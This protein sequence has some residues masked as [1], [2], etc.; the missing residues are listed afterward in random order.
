[1]QALLKVCHIDRAEQV[2]PDEVRIILRLI[3]DVLERFERRLAAASPDG[4]SII[5]E[6]V[7]AL[8]DRAPLCLKKITRKIPERIPRKALQ[9]G[10][11][12]VDV[13][14]VPPV[15]HLLCEDRFMRS[16]RL[17]IAVDRRH[18][19]PPF[20]KVRSLHEILSE[21]LEKGLDVLRKVSVL[22]GPERVEGDFVESRDAPEIKVPSGHRIEHFGERMDRAEERIIADKSLVIFEKLFIAVAKEPFLIG[23]NI[24]ALVRPDHDVIRVRTKPGPALLV[25]LP[26]H[27][28]KKVI[29]DLTEPLQ[30]FN[31]ISVRMP[32]FIIKR[33]HA[34]ALCMFSFQNQIICSYTLCVPDFSIDHGRGIHIV[35][36]DRVLIRD[37][38]DITDVIQSVVD[39]EPVVREADAAQ[40]EQIAPSLQIHLLLKFHHSHVSGLKGPRIN[41]LEHRIGP[42][43]LRPLRIL[44]SEAEKRVD[45]LPVEFD[46]HFDREFA[47]LDDAGINFPLVIDNGEI[48]DLRLFLTVV[49]ELGIH[50]QLPVPLSLR[51]LL[52]EVAGDVLLDRGTVVG[53]RV[54][55][56]DLLVDID[57]PLGI[58][59]CL[60]MSLVEK[61]DTVTVLGYRAEVMAD[62]EDRLPG[63]LELLELVVALGL[64]EDVTD[65][66]S[67][68]DDE[69]LRVDIDRDGK[70]EAD[71]HTGG[72][73]LHGLIDE[74][75]DVRERDDVV[76]PRIHLLA[77]E[78]H[79]RPVHIDVLEPCIFLI[80]TSAQ[81]EQGRNS[82]A[83]S[84]T[85]FGRVQNA[86]YDLKDR[87][88]SGT[89]GPD[90]AHA[91]PSSHIEADVLQR[92]DFLIALLSAESERFLQAV[93][94]LVVELILF[95]Y[96]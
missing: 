50:F 56:K 84:H 26:V 7:P 73:G 92:I 70:G 6:E 40:G 91:L 48:N 66:E 27:D 51:I 93:H 12:A 80:E 86:G 78:S 62:E 79:D 39:R 76:E 34:A 18:F 16:D 44:D 42:G 1:M 77:G 71:E 74:I 21:D 82:S 54:V 88:L 37:D 25:D 96:M 94:R 20:P 33:I 23:G 83:D 57:H 28:D 13:P 43:D 19:L 29:R 67:F 49:E 45:Q 8:D 35:E 31:D 69:D 52:V 64:E 89:V 46:L 65:G 32:V 41:A 14:L 95:C 15:L 17:Q 58:A 9:R 87:G 81:L 24:I 59:F 30:K 4:F 47:S 55:D 68:I 22:N 75:T 85:A 60:L 2:L 5:L 63:L 3:P 61:N 36:A 10:G 90:D 38:I 72:I 11:I 53:V